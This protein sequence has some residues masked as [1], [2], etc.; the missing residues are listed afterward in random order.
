MAS[1]LGATVKIARRMQISAE[2]VTELQVDDDPLIECPRNVKDKPPIQGRRPP[3]VTV[4]AISHP[5]PYIHKRRLSK[6]DR[7]QLKRER[8]QW[9]ERYSAQSS[10]SGTGTCSSVDSGS[11]L[12]E[13]SDAVSL[14]DSGAISMTP[15]ADEIPG[16]SHSPSPPSSTADSQ[17]S[18][19][20][21]T[22][23]AHTMNTDG[24]YTVCSSSSTISRGSLSA[25][26]RGKRT[27]DKPV[28]IEISE[29]EQA[30]H[31]LRRHIRKEWKKEKQHKKQLERA[32]HLSHSHGTRCVKSHHHASRP[33]ATTLQD[34][35]LDGLAR[36][37]GDLVVN[38]TGQALAGKEQI[39]PKEPSV[40]NIASLRD[41]F[42]EEGIVSAKERGQARTGLASIS[43][44][45]KTPESSIVASANTFVAK[46]AN[47]DHPRQTASARRPMPALPKSPTS[48]DRYAVECLIRMP[49][50]I[51]STECTDEDEPSL[52]TSKT[53]VQ[54]TTTLSSRDAGKNLAKDG[55]EGANKV[56]LSRIH[57]ETQKP[58]RKKADRPVRDRNQLQT[59]IDFETVWDE[60]EMDL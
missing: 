11:L 54:V 32:R 36:L 38:E 18:M 29:A 22:T 52:Q 2:G 59:F 48:G 13:P 40:V 44:L 43:P 1:G 4:N 25:R 20:Q 26:S 7:R 28:P 50:S 24:R 19:V 51:T 58:D 23:M 49:E 33:C 16:L 35:Y 47:S 39:T 6:K 30:Q 15:P 57:V 46:P 37:F 56:V 8:E 5:L 31:A 14:G 12:T 17:Y 9:L 55:V 53:S 45:Q 41:Q 34:R 60:L 27:P 10:I 21:H 42:A 3:N